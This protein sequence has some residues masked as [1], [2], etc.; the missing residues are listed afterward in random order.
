MGK[1]LLYIFTLFLLPFMAII[2]CRDPFE[3]DV[4]TTDLNYL[5][6]EGF[7][8]ID[9]QESILKLSRSIPLR[10]E[11]RL[12]EESGASITLISENNES[13]EFVEKEPGTY[14]LTG[15][16]DPNLTYKINILLS[17]NQEYESD[18]M[19]P[20]IS[21][22]I[23]NV[24]FTR[25]EDGVSIHVSTQ[26]NE[27]A[28]YFL[29]DYEE[30]WL[31]RPP[32]PSPFIFNPTTN[33]I[34]LRKPE[35]QIALC[36][37]DNKVNR[38]LLENAGRFANYSIQKDMVFIPNLSEKLMTRYSFSLRQRAL[39]KDAFD[40]WEIMRKN[41]EDI[42]GIF[43]P[44]PSLIR[45]NINPV[46][47]TNKVA[48][49][50]VS[51]G[52]SRSER[53][54]INVQEVRPWPVFI[55]DYLECQLELDTI[56]PTSSYIEFSGPNFIPVVQVVNSMGAVL[57]YRGAEARCADCTLRGSNVRPEFWED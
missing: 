22:P 44:L 32:F 28:V 54:Y 18:P 51:M 20:K 16:F 27:D 45:G 19:I 53:L 43:S 3:P 23:Q 30:T 8:E 48:I 26:G 42:G 37:L 39:D 56:P 12:R 13:W 4:T 49:G 33:G 6:V 2:G 7:I 15:T 34:D 11:T 17:N 29:W 52:K 46:N 55:P 31:F 25:N 24:G 40:F 36:W 35:Q 21:P 1:R 41:T 50:Y 5:V 57:G 38:V 14:R 10:A 47:S 9:A